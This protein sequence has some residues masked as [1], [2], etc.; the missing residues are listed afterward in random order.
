MTLWVKLVST[1]ADPEIRGKAEIALCCA[2]NLCL[3]LCAGACVP[4]P[5]P[6]CVKLAILNNCAIVAPHLLML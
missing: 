1:A 4:V 5:R 6:P 2:N 3:C